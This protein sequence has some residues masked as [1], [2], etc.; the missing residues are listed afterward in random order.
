MGMEKSNN[1]KFGA[2]IFNDFQ[3]TG[4]LDFFPPSIPRELTVND[5]SIKLT[6]SERKD[7]TIAIG[8]ANY[9]NISPFVNDMAMLKGYNKRYTQLNDDDKVKLL[10]FLYSE[11][12]DDG[13]EQFIKDH[14]KFQD[15][16]IDKNKIMEEFEKDKPQ[17]EFEISVIKDKSKAQ[18]QP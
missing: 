18:K 10:Q 13:L 9:N 15:A 1:D 14:P 7:L 16:E 8:K 5:E 6:P 11:A 17:L 2:I 4:N 3:R 12:S